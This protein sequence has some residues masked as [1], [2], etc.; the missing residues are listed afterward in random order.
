MIVLLHVFCIIRVHF[1]I[2]LYF[3]IRQ[4]TRLFLQW[5]VLTTVFLESFFLH[6]AHNVNQT[7]MDKYA[8]S[9]F[10]D[11]CRETFIKKQGLL[12]NTEKIEAMQPIAKRIELNQ[13]IIDQLIRPKPEDYSPALFA[14]ERDA[15]RKE[16]EQFHNTK[17]NDKYNFKNFK[18]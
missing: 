3:V 8:L 18:F 1:C 6:Y 4:T 2:N 11:T 17:L 15:F 5:I 16:Y 13:R 9:K 12:D 10:V 7:Y 14:N